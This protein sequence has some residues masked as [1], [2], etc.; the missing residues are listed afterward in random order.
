MSHLETWKNSASSTLVPPCVQRSVLQTRLW[1][2]RLESGPLGMTWEHPGPLFDSP[3]DCHL[4]FRV[5]DLL[6]RG[7][8]GVLVLLAQQLGPAE[9]TT[10]PPRRVR[11]YFTPEWEDLPTALPRA[12]AA[13]V[14][15]CWPFRRLGGSMTLRWFLSSASRTLWRS[16]VPLLPS[17]PCSARKV[18]ICRASLF[19]TL[20]FSP[21]QRFESHLFRVLLL[22]LPVWPSSRL[23]WPSPCQL[24]ESRGSGEARL[25]IG[26]CG[27]THLSRG[28]RQSVNQC[29]L[30]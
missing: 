4:L 14:L 15:A 2:V 11:G 25:R 27:G 9:A 13:L 12:L 30:A 26:V 23:P 1:H 20:P 22:L 16:L 10:S 6:A 8:V 21:L 7:E 19:T 5:A 24:F 3:K 29:V 18:A 28:W 17:G